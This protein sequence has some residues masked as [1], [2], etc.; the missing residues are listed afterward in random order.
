LVIKEKGSGNIQV[1]IINEEIDE[2]NQKI[3][4]IKSRLGEEYQGFN[5]FSQK[6]D[7]LQ[8]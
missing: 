4:E 8:R 2:V 5:E 7:L 1:K 3:G 6:R